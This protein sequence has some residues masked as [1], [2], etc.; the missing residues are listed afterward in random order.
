M[1]V[2]SSVAPAT[3]K[4]RRSGELIPADSLLAPYISVDPGR[5]H[6]EPVFRG[7]RVPIQALF[8][9]LRAGDGFEKLLEDFEGVNRE[10]VIGVVDLAARGLL[11]GLR[12][13]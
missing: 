8:D 6:G 5:M 4:N 1:S 7:T 11:G 13:L 12:L 2:A 9:Y 3:K 10:Q